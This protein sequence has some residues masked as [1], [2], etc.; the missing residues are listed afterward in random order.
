MGLLAWSKSIMHGDDN[1]FLPASEAGGAEDKEAELAGLNFMSAVDAHMKWKIR[2]EDCINGTS[3]EKL[4]VDVV[5]RDDQC[6]LGKWINDQGAQMFG[7]SETFSDLK[8]H[9]ADFHRCAAGVLAAAQSG[10]TAGALKLLHRGDYVMES[11]RIKKLLAR[12]FVIASEDE[13]ID[14]HV[15]WK[16]RLKDYIQ[17]VGKEDLKIDTVSR[18]DQCT[19]GQWINGI[20]GERF[21]RMPGFSVLK[22]CHA[23]FHRCA[24]DVLVVA[25]QDKRRALQMLEEGA[26]PDASKQ[27]AAAIADLFT[28]QKAG[29]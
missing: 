17:G 25:E 6:E 9:H 1:A 28:G 27:V 12:M 26:Y 3:A 13:A 19:L 22:S 11:Q 15:R 18:D 8:A 2:L 23:Q 16:A 4:Q 29:R 21:G 24:K 7:F 10:D 20:G 14:A 5:C